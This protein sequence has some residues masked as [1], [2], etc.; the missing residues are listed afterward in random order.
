MQWGYATP[1][2]ALADFASFDRS[3]LCF[4]RLRRMP[5]AAWQLGEQYCWNG[6]VRKNFSGHALRLHLA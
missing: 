1:F 2:Q 3:R 6:S 4:S 5:S